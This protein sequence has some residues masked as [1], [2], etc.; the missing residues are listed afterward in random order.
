MMSSP[1]KDPLFEQ[2]MQHLQNAEWDAAIECFETLQKRYPDNKAVKHALE[3][4]LLKA[5]LEKE[6]HIQPRRWAFPTKRYLIGLGIIFILG[7]FIAIGVYVI[8]QRI[9]PVIAEM[10]SQNQTQI[11]LTQGWEY[12]EQGDLDNAERA[13]KQA[14]SLDPN[15]PEIQKALAALDKQ[16]EL[17]A[18]YE[19]GVHLQ[20]EGNYDEALK[21]LMD[22]VAQTTNYRDAPQR[23]QEIQQQKELQ[24]LFQ[25]AESAYLAGDYE[26]AADLFEQLRTVNSAFEKEEV[27]KRLYE[28]YM[29]L[30]YSTLN[31]SYVST[32][33][34]EKAL[35]YFK[36]A[37]TEFPRDTKALREKELA[38]FYL[39]ALKAIGEGRWQAAALALNS[40]YQQRPNYLR[41]R[42][43]PMLYEAL[44]QSG[45]LYRMA[46]D[47]PQAYE[48]YR[49]ACNL[50]LKDKTLCKARLHEV[51]PLITPTATPT[52]TPT[53]TPTPTVTPTPTPIPPT[54]TPRPLPMQKGRIAFYSD[55]PERPGIWTMDPSGRNRQY[56]GNST[57]ARKEF[58]ALFE[59][60]RI[61]PDGRYRAYVTTGPG[62]ETPQIYI[63]GEVNQYGIAPTWKVTVGFHAVCYDPMW[64][65]DGTKLVFVS[66]E[67]G[68]DDI[69]VINIDGS[70]PINLTPNTW[71]WDKHPSWSPDGRRI[72]FWSNRTGIKNI[73]IMDADGRNVRNISNTSWDEWK[74]IWIR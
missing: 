57:N 5:D 10:K 40:I 32:V 19:K 39:E 29:N 11:Y 51:I 56:Y 63:Q 37:L 62:D 34:V 49:L 13:F 38:E 41:G 6:V 30:G 36:K 73:Y 14:A 59:K 1:P 20:E 68:S 60:Y 58:E 45:D 52:P 42:I 50:P 16:R 55:N 15:N 25:Q 35:S 48:Q 71:E 65:P 12:L 23:I 53:A 69:W 46:D 27:S 4:A 28:A 2:G 22:Y 31:A 18:L 21:A 9:L 66:E 3:E 47:L 43:V 54:P 64:S 24:E 72:V 8:N 33:E 70:N 17:N 26:K 74:P 7:V 67:N 44:I 61:S